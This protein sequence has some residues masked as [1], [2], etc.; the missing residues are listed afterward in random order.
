MRDIF[1]GMPSAPGFAQI[2]CA[3]ILLM[4]TP[5]LSSRILAFLIACC[6]FPALTNAQVP[7]FDSMY[8]FGD[9]LADNGNVLIQSR[10]FRVNPP[11]PPVGAFFDGRFS[12]GFIAV[13]FLWESLS[14]H[15]PDSSRR[16]KPFLAALRS[17]GAIDFAY[18]GTGTALLDQTPG[19]MWA[20][21]LKGQVELF[22]LALLGRK[23]S[24]RSLYVIA[25]GANDYRDDPFNVPMDPEE[26]ARNIEEAIGSLYKIGAR[27][28]M[29]LN[30]PDLGKVPANMVDPATGEPDPLRSAAATELSG[31]HN[32]ALD[33]ALA[34]VRVRYPR[35]HLIPV[36][37]DIPFD[38]LRGALG[39]LWPVPAMETIAPGTSPCLFVDPA[40]CPDLPDAAFNVDLGF[41]FWDIVHPTTQAHRHL[42]QYLFD[43]LTQ[44]YR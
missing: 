43:R 27:D 3:I 34:R 2:E 24:S 18:G 33:A 36:D 5:Q 13:E 15:R 10:I 20:P 4:K 32:E 29:V 1:C 26:V 17:E 8:V 35:L 42:G 39:D 41:L 38:Q 7:R 16:L 11:V 37:L 31:L 6:L 22:K 14:G 21:G 44:S 9:S 23:P 30:L 19:G 25:T 12:N 40:T 28:V